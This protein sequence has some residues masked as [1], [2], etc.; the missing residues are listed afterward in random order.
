MILR[1]EQKVVELPN[2]LLIP[3]LEKGDQNGKALIML[4]GI[5]DSCVAFEP[6]LPFLSKEFRSLA[7][8]LRGHGDAGKPETGYSTSDFVEDLVLFLDKLGIEKAVLLGASSGG[9]PARSF[10]AA[11]PERTEGLILLG[12]PA[13]LGD[14]PGVKKLWDE[15]ISKLED[16]ISENFVQSFSQGLE[17]GNIPEDYLEIIVKENLKAPARVWIKTIQGI[18]EEPFPGTLGQ[19]KAETLILWGDQD[20]IS[21]RED[22]EMLEKAISNASLRVLSGLGHLLYWESPERVAKEINEFLKSNNKS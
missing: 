19:I 20:V 12:S 4:H 5:A 13:V 9:F 3:F 16:P 6:M 10:A 1:Q 11:Y 15:V 8:T 21:T 2:H 18:M 22:Q 14:K 7:V 17:T